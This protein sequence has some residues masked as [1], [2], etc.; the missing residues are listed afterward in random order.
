MKKLA[1]TDPIAA[2]VGALVTLLGSL[3]LVEQL[4]LTSDQVVQAGGA[5]VTIAATIRA[6]VVHKA[7]KA[8]PEDES[9]QA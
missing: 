2:I 5:I 3:G 6:I 9:T 7:G 8:A 1:K 4:G